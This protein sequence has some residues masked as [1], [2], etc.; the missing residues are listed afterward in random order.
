MAAILVTWG[1]AY[2]NTRPRLTLKLS[3]PVICQYGCDYRQNQI[4]DVVPYPVANKAFIGLRF[5][6]ANYGKLPCSVLSWSLHVGKHQ[7][8]NFGHYPRWFNGA[9]TL[10]AERVDCHFAREAT[11]IPLPDVERY[12]NLYQTRCASVGFEIPAEWLRAKRAS[13]VITYSTYRL[14]R[15]RP[16]ESKLRFSIPEIGLKQRDNKSNQREW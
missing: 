8:T 6:I 12:F 9:D 14:F 16:H 2:F 15:N 7:I 11:F 10:D 3:E 13:L 4:G 1:A 5:F